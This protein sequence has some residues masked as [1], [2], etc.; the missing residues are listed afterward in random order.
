MSYRGITVTG[1]GVNG[2]ELLC[3]IKRSHYEQETTEARTKCEG[4][5]AP[6]EEKEKKK[7]NYFA[8]Y[9]S[10]GI[11]DRAGGIICLAGTE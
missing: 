3:E 4:T 11:I 2:D 6:L 9:R 8:Y 5:K 10:F 7:K 1:H